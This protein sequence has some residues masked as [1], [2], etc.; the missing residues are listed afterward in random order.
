MSFS[1]YDVSFGENPSLPPAV[2]WL[3][4]ANIGVYFL[5]LVLF[6]SHNVALWFGL[7]PEEFPANWWTV[8]TYMFVHGGFMHL[9]LNMLMLWMFG[10][11][12]EWE[13]GTRSFTYFYLWCGLG[14][15]IFHLL[16]VRHGIVVGAS[17][18]VVGVVLVYALRWPEEDLYL[19]GIMPMR[20]RWLAIWMI[21]WNVGMAI[22]ELTGYSR[23]NTA[24]M[25]HVGGLA[26]A[27]LYLNAPN[28]G[29]LDRIRKHVKSVPDETE[30][31]PVPRSPRGPRASRRGFEELHPSDQ[32][33]AQSNSLFK[34]KR[35]PVKADKQ[36]KG[37]DGAVDPASLALEI[38]QLLDK[39]SREGI[40]SLTV[41]EKELLDRVSRRLREG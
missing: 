28:S 18:A 24:W 33:V 30:I 21:A 29:S 38:D 17:G 1:K 25:A 16:F 35:L 9:G 36:V 13:F 23:G 19:F 12:I 15:A 14:G 7:A 31:R 26:F 8:G 32:V 22:A 41:S 4:A 27:W 10:P 34:T 11:R 37:D 39:I 3:L 40:E 20:A 6:G 5:Q 2:K